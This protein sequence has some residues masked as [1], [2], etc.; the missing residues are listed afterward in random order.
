MFGMLHDLLTIPVLSL[1]FCLAKRT[2]SPRREADFER[3]SGFL[4]KSSELTPWN[5][6]FKK[7]GVMISIP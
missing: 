1:F 4:A 2:K 6:S 5:R 3:G 7:P